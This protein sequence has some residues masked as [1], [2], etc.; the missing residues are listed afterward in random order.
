MESSALVDAIQTWKCGVDSY[1]QGFFLARKVW[2]SNPDKIELNTAQVGSS[3]GQDAPGSPADNVGYSWNISSLSGYESGFFQD[4]SPQ[5]CYVCFADPSNYPNAPGWMLR[6]LLVLVKHRWGLDKVQVLCYRDI[7][8][9]RDQA[10]SFVLN[11]EIDS[12]KISNSDEGQALQG[13]M[14]KVTGW[15]RN[16]SGKLL[17]RVVDLTAYM[18]PK[19]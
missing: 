16:P 18:D 17:G 8:S 4:A 14:P 19:R 1:Q 11:L 9:N 5:D 13:Q 10:R 3:G 7:H 12:S 6:N 15:E 2:H